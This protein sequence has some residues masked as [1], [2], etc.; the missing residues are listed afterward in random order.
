MN[1][2]MA[3]ASPLFQICSMWSRKTVMDMMCSPVVVFPAERGW[4]VM[5]L[6]AVVGAVLFERG[7]VRDG[8]RMG[9][10]ADGVVGQRGSRHI[11]HSG[12]PSG[13]VNSPWVT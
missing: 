11:R 4:V 10:G 12:G 7:G 8:D 13:R 6:V 3:L 5:G 9:L 1:R 2:W